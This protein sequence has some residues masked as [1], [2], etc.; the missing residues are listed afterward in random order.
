MQCCS[1]MLS[2]FHIYEVAED[3]LH[4]QNSTFIDPCHYCNESPQT[5]PRIFALYGID[6]W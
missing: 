6:L 5:Y 2:V 4:L 1:L 3:R